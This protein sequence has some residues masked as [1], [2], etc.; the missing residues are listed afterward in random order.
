MA[1]KIDVQFRKDLEDLGVDAD[2]MGD[3]MDI[4]NT[5]PNLVPYE[6]KR[7]YNIKKNEEK[8]RSL[9]LMDIKPE[10]RSKTSQ[11]QKRK[12][13]TPK[14]K[15]TTPL[16]PAR[17][18]ARIAGIKPI[19]YNTSEYL[20]EVPL[21][22]Q[23]SERPRAPSRPKLAFNDI[24]D[25]KSDSAGPILDVLKKTVDKNLLVTPPKLKS[26][27]STILEDIRNLH[28]DQSHIAK[29][30]KVRLSSMAIH[31]GHK[32]I[33]AGGSKQGEV[34][35]F[36]PGEKKVTIRLE[37]HTDLVGGCQFSWNKLFTSSYDSSIRMFDSETL[38]YDQL[39][40]DP[41]VWFRSLNV[42]NENEVLVAGTNG[43]VLKV[44]VRE[45]SKVCEYPAK[46]DFSKYGSLWALDHSKYDTNYFLSTSNNATIAAWDHRNTKHPVDMNTSH[47]KTVSSAIFDPIRGKRIV[48]VG[49]DDKVCIL[50][51]SDKAKLSE[52]KKFSHCNNTGRWLT[53]FQARWHPS[54]DELFVIG[55]MAQPRRVEIYNMQGKMECTLSSENIG[56]I[57]SLVQFHHS[58]NALVCGNG[59]GYCYIFHND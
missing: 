21:R 33:V 39:Y 2:I 46:P 45:N 24:V 1:K 14:P 19:H 20:V 34:G 56:S 16:E 35:L 44:D 41:E 50:D 29:L 10:M 23:R 5:H 37:P 42:Y 7:Q 32:L 13:W 11:S 36:M 30:C 22:S 6:C 18:S 15:F 3:I 59:S 38:Q 27:D 17:K 54:S 57:Q 52:V 43:Q 48:S 4:H 55:S 28:L 12:T 8:L 25:V 51:F 26:E 31:P 58:Q 49:Y 40:S 53:K 47:S 9:N